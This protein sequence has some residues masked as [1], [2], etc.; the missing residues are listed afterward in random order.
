MIP[1][2][3]LKAQLKEIRAEIE[4][5][6]RE[7]LDSTIFV[8]GP[9]LK[10][11]EERI[12]RFHGVSS[13]IGVASGTDALHLTLRAAGIGPGD[14]VITTPFTFFATV[15]AILYTGARP[16]FV[17]I[18]PDTF[19]IS[20]D[21][22]EK[23]IT[24]R[25]KAIL[26]VHL[27]GHPADMQ[28]I[29]DIATRYNLLVIEDCAQAFGARQGLKRVGTFG[30]AGAFS[31]YPSKNLGAYGDAGMIITDNESLAET[32]R[33][34]RNHGSAGQYIHERIGYNSRLD[35]FQAAV[36]LVKL[37]RIEIYNELRR[38]KARLYTSLID[39]NKAR[40]PIEKEGFYH[41]YHQYTIRSS[42]R[43]ELQKR[44]RQKGISSVVYYPV[45]LHLQKALSFLGYREGDLPEAERA[46]KE[47]L[48]LPIYPELEEDLITEIADIINKS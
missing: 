47:V 28:K 12:A 2:V 43:D 21:L 27:Y 11:L 39:H 44:L 6:L 34:L 29:M 8:L 20:A 46:S 42:R 22:I 26:P 9:K 10:E 41:V 25:T 48:S 31:F 40:P 24:P 23:E 17:D 32:I 16:V 1:M 30:L 14:E 45:P 37:Q 4:E 35:E 13:A 3:D 5:S 7:I 18:E 15:E 36:L 33:S 19:N 38:Q